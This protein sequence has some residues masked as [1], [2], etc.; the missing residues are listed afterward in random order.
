VTER[1]KTLIGKG[2]LGWHRFERQ[3]DR[4]G[5][6]G[7]Y[8]EDGD[9]A[10]KDEDIPTDQVGVLVATVLETKKSYHLGDWGRGIQTKTPS[11]GDRFEL[12]RGTLHPQYY[13]E[14]GPYVGMKPENDRYT[15]F[16]AET[17]YRLHSQ[18][19]ALEF[20]IGEDG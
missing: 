19:I 17:L 7:I 3:S 15:V 16:D 12:G 9:F 13:E 18:I 8:N 20:E 4:Y 1:T 10:I 14:Y 6:V 5:S 11:V 2:E